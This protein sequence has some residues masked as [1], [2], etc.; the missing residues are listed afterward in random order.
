[1]K[2]LKEWG[3]VIRALECGDQTVILRKGG[4]LETASGF[5][6]ESGRFLLYPTAE[7]QGPANVREEFHGHLRDSPAASDHSS[8]T[9]YADVLAEADIAAEETADMLSEFHIWTKSYIDQRRAWQ[10]QR[11]LRALF[12]R[13]YRMPAMQVPQ[14]PEYGGCKSWIDVGGEAGDGTPALGDADVE[15]RLGRFREI[16]N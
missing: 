5:R 11:P 14:K 4:I 2:A 9:S 13:V 3:A 8:V 7:H 15:S 1:M 6:T 10:G 16:T 12:L